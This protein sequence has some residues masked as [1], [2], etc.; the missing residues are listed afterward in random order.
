MWQPLP[1]SKCG[2]KIPKQIKI[3]P[4]CQGLPG[5]RHDGLQQGRADLQERW[6]R[7]RFK[8]IEAA[9][10]VAIKERPSL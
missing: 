7:D 5:E 2:A 8:N 10:Q 6:R 9:G 3:V 1:G 4:A